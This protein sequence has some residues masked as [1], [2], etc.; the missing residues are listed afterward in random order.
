MLKRLF[1]QTRPE[2]VGPGPSPC[3]ESEPRQVAAAKAA[4]VRPAGWWLWLAAMPGTSGAGCGA[5]ANE[6]AGRRP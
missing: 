1:G 3:G 2:P 6:R 5:P 4:S